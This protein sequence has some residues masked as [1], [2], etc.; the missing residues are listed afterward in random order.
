MSSCNRVK[1]V[2]M[3][4]EEP[5]YTRTKKNVPICFLILK[6]KLF[7]NEKEHIDK[8]QCIAFG[9]VI[10]AVRKRIARYEIPMRAKIIG[11]VRSDSWTNPENGKTRYNMSVRIKSIFNV[12]PKNDKSN[13]PLEPE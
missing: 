12:K 4:E 10:K 11:E 8:F 1:L 5:T 2:G 13:I 6:V 7:Y 9:R 3:L